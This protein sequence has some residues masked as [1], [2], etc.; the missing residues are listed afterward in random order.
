MVAPNV[1]EENLEIVS[2]KPATDSKL[3]LRHLPVETAYLLL[4]RTAR[5]AANNSERR[6][7]VGRPLAPPRLLD[8]ESDGS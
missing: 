7:P 3:A 2:G 1:L 8:G 6:R 5:Q 4:R